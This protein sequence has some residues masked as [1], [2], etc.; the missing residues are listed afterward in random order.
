MP[1]G[2]ISPSWLHRFIVRGG[3]VCPWQ[4]TPQ[5]RNLSGANA[6]VPPS[7]SRFWDQL[8]R[9][10][11]VTAIFVDAATA[12]PFLPMREFHLNDTGSLPVKIRY[13]STSLRPAL[14]GASVRVAGRRC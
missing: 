3:E 12:Q 4:K 7:S 13:P 2:Q 10:S 11:F 5:H 9:L 6:S 1:G 14:G 8:V